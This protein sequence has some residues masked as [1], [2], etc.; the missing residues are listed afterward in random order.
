MLTTVSATCER[1]YTDDQEVNMTRPIPAWKKR[2]P[3]PS[4]RAT[5]SRIIAPQNPTGAVDNFMP[6]KPRRKLDKNRATP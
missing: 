1:V 6:R 2:A 5:T 3:I 4:R